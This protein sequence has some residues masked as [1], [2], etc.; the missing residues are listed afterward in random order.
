MRKKDLSAGLVFFIL[1]TAGI[2][3]MMYGSRSL[4]AE[5][6]AAWQTQAHRDVERITDTCLFWLSLLHSQV[7]G[8]GALFHSSELVVE[9]EL[10]E[11]MDIISLVEA[12]VPLENLAFVANDPDGAWRVALSTNF[13]GLLRQ[14]AHLEDRPEIRT[15]LEQAQTMTGEVVMGPVFDLEG[16]QAAILA[17][18][19]DNGA[20]RGVVA[21]SVDFSG[22]IKGLYALHIPPGIVLS[23]E[24][25]TADRGRIVLGPSSP[26][27]ETIKSFSIKADTGGTQL[28]FHWHILPSYLN[29]PATGLANAVLFGGIVVVLLG[30]GLVGSLVVQ[31]G[32]VSRRVSQ[33]TADLETAAAETERQQ[34][35]ADA[36]R[37]DAV[38]QRRAA[39]QAQ[40]AAEQA[41]TRAETA[42]QDKNHLL[43]NIP[44]NIVMADAELNITYLNPA[45]H[46][47]LN[48]IKAHLRT[49]IDNIIGQSLAALHTDIGNQLAF[50]GDPARLPHRCRLR[51]GPETVDILGLATQDREGDFV[52]PILVWDF[53]TAQVQ[54]EAEQQ[55][56]SA[57]EKQ[58][59]ENERL[60]ATQLQSK[61]DNILRVVQA[62]A[63]GDLSLSLPVSGTDAIGQLGEGLELFFDELRL[64]I[65]TLGQNARAMAE[66]SRLL[67]DISRRMEDN[68]G[69]TST[70]ADAVSAD[71][72]TVSNSIQDI[73]DAVVNTTSGFDAIRTNARQ[74]AQ[75]V[76]K[77][78]EVRE[79]TTATIGRLDSS[80]AEIGSVIKLITSITEQTNLLALNATI[81][82]ARAGEAG[83]GF[84]VVA[85]EVKDLSRKTEEA[86][87]QVGQRVD[88]IQRDI[89]EAIGA[90]GDI[91]TIIDQINALQSGIAAA[92]EEQT[93]TASG[94][95]QRIGLAADSSVSITGTIT[96]VAA[97]AQDTKMR[98]G[99]VQA[100]AQAL[101]DM[102]SQLQVFVAR[103][104][105]KPPSPPPINAQLNIDH[106]RQVLA[107]RQA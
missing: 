67:S 51:L 90:I 42:N 17:L 65:D 50:W 32:R 25:V 99:E 107:S 62:A 57:R 2:G 30:F 72:G 97:A 74:A 13:D 33:R 1:L 92:V 78:V 79:A 45:M 7:R 11:A 38:G 73:A 81:E 26:P 5:A 93:G 59:I 75:M 35:A 37:K 9:D 43:A 66:A 16:R 23:I 40:A 106:L 100:A 22:L 39:E 34:Q 52:G 63:E 89:E 101:T 14:D 20:E 41:A 19:S 64:S 55:A 95:A 8:F 87:G 83:K 4:R 6:Q 56:S 85:N 49:G 53:V 61:V 36:A 12:A 47:S 77:A 86:T 46:R 44:T 96:G 24:T 48:T 71:A 58:Q 21:S 102:A 91:G 18:A 3:A 94:M 70:Q 28:V 103:F 31:N 54:L 82:A 29:G 98:A 104:K 60:Q 27:V 68:A 105:L 84:A 69:Q 88:A 15:A 76:H 80:S 10:F